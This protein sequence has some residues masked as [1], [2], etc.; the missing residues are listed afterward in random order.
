MTDD[1]RRAGRWQGEISAKMSDAERR[2]T[3]LEK[4]VP[5]VADLKAKQGIIWAALGALAM[6]AGSAAFKLWTGGA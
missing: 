6:L 2:L 3:A 1:E 5:D 4:I